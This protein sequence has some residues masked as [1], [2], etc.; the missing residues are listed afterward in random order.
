M[1]KYKH[2]LIIVEG[3]TGLGKSTMAHFIA[4]QLVYNNIPTQWI[5]EGEL[6]HPT[7]VE[8]DK[9]LPAYMEDSLMM[10]RELV[11]KLN[12]EE[13]VCVIEA[14][15]F[16][17]LIET[18]YCHGLEPDEIVAYG[19]ELQRVIKP[20][21]P[22]LVYLVHRD[23]TAALNGNFKNRGDGF[24]DF[25]IQLVERTEIAKLK[26][27]KGYAGVFPFWDS[28]ASLT[29]LLF[30]KFHISKIS[31]DVSTGNWLEI[32]HQVMKFL[33]IQEHKDPEISKGD[34]EAFTGLY[35]IQD[36]GED[37]AV[38]YQDGS[39][40][41]DL[42]MNVK[43][44][45]IQKSQNRFFV[46]KWHFEIIFEGSESG[47]ITAFMVAGEDVDYLKAVGLKA[48]KVNKWS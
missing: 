6:K 32:N 15:F 10:W 25:V 30:T 37:C 24:K 39:L 35:R 1:N 18:L 5:H 31:L 29:D 12:Q 7:S 20:A 45:L 13:Q 22:A 48:E 40:K 46:E 8:L 11:D 9:G 23:T 17:N 26:G 42:F 28:F 38:I 19:M 41:T 44:R 21:N 33:G 27:W 4:R 3:L 16:N 34:A 43:T 14:S 36:T 2:K 47:E